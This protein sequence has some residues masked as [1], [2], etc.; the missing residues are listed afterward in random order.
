MGINEVLTHN[1]IIVWQRIY[2]PKGTFI[3]LEQ[4]D[5]TMGHEIFHSILNN[6]RLFDVE[7]LTAT[8]QRVRVH[9]YYTSRWEQQYIMFRKWEKL[10]LN[11]GAFNTEVSNF[12]SFDILKPKIQPIFNNYLKSTL[13]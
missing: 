7:E 3:S 6:A 5:L 12:K 13:K 10:N 2:L 1:N 4:L 8:H 9:E 11:M